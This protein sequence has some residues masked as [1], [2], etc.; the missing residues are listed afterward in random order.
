MVFLFFWIISFCC[1][2]LCQT[3]NKQTNK[4][5]ADEK[6]IEWW[7]RWWRKIK[8]RKLISGFF[9]KKRFYPESNG[10]ILLIRLAVIFFFH[11]MP[12]TPWETRID[13]LK[14]KKSSY[15]ARSTQYVNLPRFVLAIGHH[16]NQPFIKMRKFFFWRIWKCCCTRKQHFIFYL[17][18]TKLSNQ[19]WH[20]ELYD[21]TIEL[22][23]K[24]K[25]TKIWRSAVSSFHSFIHSIAL[26]LSSPLS[27][28]SILEQNKIIII[29]LPFT[30]TH[31]K[32]EDISQFSSQV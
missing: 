18:I 30:H 3:Q 29:I 6:L 16:H 20:F 8:W 17:F 1:F 31:R 2:D 12:K 32:N 27:L 15:S 19:F 7:W 28:Y 4:N 13:K 10:D 25:K 26:L 24:E 11:W 5:D 22:N 9:P 21:M 23:S 14:E